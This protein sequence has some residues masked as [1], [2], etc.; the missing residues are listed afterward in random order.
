MGIGD[1]TCPI[2]PAAVEAMKK[3]PTTR[4]TLHISRIWS[5]TGLRMAT[6]GQCRRR[7][8]V[9]WSKRGYR[10]DFRSDGAKAI[11]ATIG[12]I[13]STECRVAV[14]DPVYPVYVDTNVMAGRAGTPTPDGCWSRI[15]YLPYSRKCIHTGSP[16]R[17]PP[18]VIYLK[19]PKQS[20]RHDSTPRRTR[21]MG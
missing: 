4:A 15:S 12:D 18:D 14:T 5:R 17:Q 9:A 3:R 20:N 19:L 13:I 8:Y 10:R 21:P 1:V 2:C 11:Q 6:P 7:L 16:D